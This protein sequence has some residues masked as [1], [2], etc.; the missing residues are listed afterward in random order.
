MQ[1]LRSSRQLYLTHQREQKALYSLCKH[2]YSVCSIMG[3]QRTIRA[4]QEHGTALTHGQGPLSLPHHH[5]PYE[6]GERVNVG[7]RSTFLVGCAVIL[8]L[9]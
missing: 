9:L 7:L 1:A 6:Y 2:T 4:K 8:S 5:V 3:V